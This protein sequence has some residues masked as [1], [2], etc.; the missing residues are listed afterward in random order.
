MRLPI[1]IYLSIFFS[2]AIQAENKIFLNLESAVHLGRTNSIIL[3]TLSSRKESFKLLLTEKWRNYL[4]RVGVSYFG[5][6][7]LNFNQLDSAYND[8][9]ITI[10]QLLYDGGENA[11]DIE[12]AKL[13]EL[14]NSGDFR[15]TNDKLAF[16]IR[17]AYLETL[18]SAS[19]LYLAQNSYKRVVSQYADILNQKKT[20]FA[21]ELQK[22]EVNTRFREIQLAEEKARGQLNLSLYN[23]KQTLSLD[24][25]VELH[26]EENPLDD[27]IVLIPNLDIDKLVSHAVANKEELKKSQLSI[28]IAKLNKEKAENYWKPKISIGAY[29]GQNVN[30]LLPVRN[31]IYGFNFT[32][33]SQIG[34]NTAKTSGNYGVQSAGSGIQRIEGFGNQPVGQGDN[35]FNSADIKFW[36]ELSYTRKI[37]ENKIQLEESIGKHKSTEAEVKS[38]VY[39]STDKL[40][41][42]YYTIRI[43]NTKLYQQFESLRLLKEKYTTG[44][45]KRTDLLNLEVEFLKAQDDLAES[46]INYIIQS[47]RIS[48]ATG[49]D[50]KHLNLFKIE[51]H[52]GNSLLKAILFKP[53]LAKQIKEEMET[54]DTK[55]NESFEKKYQKR[56]IKTNDYFFEN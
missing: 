44:F 56:K 8:I 51:K 49:I 42:Y 45:S 52:K 48:L 36:D 40:F 4:P 28:E 11:K 32:I 18:L 29:A 24:P 3:N 43:A 15:I 55:E 53:E 14:V 16:E 46:F 47:Y 22:I 41:E 31:E 23:L 38:E 33:S 37:L 34:S 7:N 39:K 30:G 20:G 17:K 54:K 10:N 9:R 5:L 13:Q 12:L 26:L 19:K 27:F 1:W 21:I 50:S 2:S 6:K 35:A 25:S